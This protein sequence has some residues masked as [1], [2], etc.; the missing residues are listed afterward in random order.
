MRRNSIQSRRIILDIRR[1]EKETTGYQHQRNTCRTRSIGK[2]PNQSRWRPSAGRAALIVMRCSTSDAKV[3]ERASEMTS[4]RGEIA[5]VPVV[6][7]FFSH[8]VCLDP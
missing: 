2:Y 7:P 3:N 1:R 6:F 8:P 5:F 4:E